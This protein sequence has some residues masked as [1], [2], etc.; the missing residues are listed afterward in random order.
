MNHTKGPWRNNHQRIFAGDV[1]VADSF[2]TE[3]SEANAQLIASAPE[4]YELLS[5]INEAFY[6]RS[7]KKHWLELM[8]QTKPLLQKARGGK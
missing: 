2:F 5:K 3:Q 6:T 8:E 1:P 4:L 7:T